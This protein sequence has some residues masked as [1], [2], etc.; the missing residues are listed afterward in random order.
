MKQSAESWVNDFEMVRSKL[1]M[2]MEEHEGFKPE[3]AQKE[4]WKSFEILCE[5][6]GSRQ[7]LLRQKKRKQQSDGQKKSRAIDA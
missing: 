3:Q 1:G 2:P 6:I 5:C 7:K 4:D